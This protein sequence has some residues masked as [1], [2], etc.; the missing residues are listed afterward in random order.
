M[1][2][3]IVI[4]GVAALVAAIASGIL[5]SM[6]NRDISAWTAWGFLLP[7]VVLVFLLLPK[8]PGPR[9]R[10]RTLDEEDAAQAHADRY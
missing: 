6:K 5:A 2:R 10:R 8:R 4:W 1:V 3:G 9:P 7:P